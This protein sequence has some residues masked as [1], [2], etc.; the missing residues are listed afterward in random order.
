[1]FADSR[2]ELKDFSPKDINAANYNEDFSGILLPKDVFANN[3][4]PNSDIGIVFSLYTS[5]QMYPLINKTLDTFNVAST[6]VSAILIGNDTKFNASIYIVLKLQYEVILM[7][8]NTCICVCSN[9]VCTKYVHNF[10]A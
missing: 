3:D 4:T 1:M 9:F 10:I 6:I 7:F 8:K 5:S 2:T